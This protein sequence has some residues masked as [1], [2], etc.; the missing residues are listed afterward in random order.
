MIALV[1]MLTA[2][3]GAVT[4]QGA[5]PAPAAAGVA[6]SPPLVCPVRPVSAADLVVMLREPAP[7]DPESENP[8][9]DAVPPDERAAIGE[10]VTSWTGCL[11][12]G[13]VP[14]LLGLFTADGVRRL[15][16]ERSPLVGGPA[17]IR[18]AIL[19]IS[20]VERLR[21]GRIAARV[22]IDPS[23][24][25]NAPPE[26]LVFVN[27]QG[28]DG[29]WRVDHL[30][31]ASQPPVMDNPGT[32]N[33]DTSPRALLRHPIAPGP[34]VPIRA[35]GPTVPMRGGDAARTG[36][37]SGPLPAADPVERWRTP[38]GWHSDAQPVVA[39]G[40]VFFGGFSLGERVP[41]LAAVDTATGGVR[42][43]TTAPVA[44]ANFP[45]APALAGDVLFAPVQAPVA[46]VMA[47]A[48]ASGDPLWF[49]PFGFTSVTA[50]AVDA[51]AVYVAGWGLHNAPENEAAGVVFALDQRTG[52]VRWRFLA[53]ARFGPVAVGPN[54]VYV[55]SD[56]G[57]YAIDRA[58]GRKR[59]QARFSPGA[60]ETATVA[61]ETVVFAGSEV[62][63]AQTGVFALDAG[64]GALRWRVD[65]PPTPGARAGTAAADG[66]VVVS[67]WE[68]QED[69]SARGV[70][71]L[72]AYDLGSGEALWVFQP[73]TDDAS[74]HPKGTG[75]LTTP[76]IAGG[77]VLFGV[78]VR[79]PSPG[80]S[81]NADGIYAVDG[82]TGI[83]RW[84]ASATT[85]IRSAPAILDG[86]IYA[87]GG[88]RTR[89]GA[90]GGTLLAFGPE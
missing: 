72:R 59:W 75:S 55:S 28:E 39:R 25:G 48:A 34:G 74:G 40:L 85:P 19:A 71:T 58:T 65:L 24:V 26:T 47:V 5:T 79:D 18:I 56:R 30:R 14:A 29:T 35:P 41:L 13:N 61:A 15:L 68:T 64:S 60:G 82:E 80:N 49:A 11:A 1:L 70:P 76:V 50:P 38:A 51:D 36:V 6:T 88:S 69:D 54:T 84:R 77:V 8:R 21:D 10:L 27:E 67:R 12:S 87:M 89:G 17:G 16:G 57:L 3:P 44:W 23:G 7:E 62:T 66:L 2:L 53:P 42:W 31:A 32:T 63:S 81:G 4:A 45:D 46:G 33:R 78:A 20:D 22:A 83:L 43:Q 37:Q 86:A 9:G 90:N 73:S 52:R